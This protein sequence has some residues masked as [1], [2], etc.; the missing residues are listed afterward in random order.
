MEKSYTE[1]L[2]NAIFGADYRAGL[3]ELEAG[4]SWE[5]CSAPAEQNERHAQD[6]RGNW[7]VMTFDYEGMASMTTKQIDITTAAAALGAKGGKSKSKRSRPPRGATA[8]DP[9]RREV[10]READHERKRRWT[11]RQRTN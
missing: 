6:A 10:G 8:N 3:P 7:F 5:Q 9:S 1:K 4:W 11:Q 2:L